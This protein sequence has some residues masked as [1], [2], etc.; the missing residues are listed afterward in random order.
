MTTQIEKEVKS[1]LT[2]LGSGPNKIAES[3]AKMKIRGIAGDGNQCAIT[4]AIRRNFK[5]LKNL[6]VGTD[7]EFT[8]KNEDCVMAYP[9]AVSKFIE[10]FDKGDYPNITTKKSLPVWQ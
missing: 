6:S 1:F 4:K 5:N 10:K 2:T 8:Y 7:I 3:L 9:V